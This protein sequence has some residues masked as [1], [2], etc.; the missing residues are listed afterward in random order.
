[1]HVKKG[2]TVLVISGNDKGRTGLVK[3]ALPAKERVIVEGVNLRWRHK[4]PSQ[5]NPKGE[6]TQIEMS[7][8]A[9]NV[10]RVEGAG[11]KKAAKKAAKAVAKG[12]EGREGSTPAARKG[13]TKAAPAAAAKPARKT[14]SASES[15]AREE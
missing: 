12:V 4:R 8:H 15:A 7:I 1:M 6:R 14:K 3:E 2:D 10:R 11:G 9:S 5:Q 13:R